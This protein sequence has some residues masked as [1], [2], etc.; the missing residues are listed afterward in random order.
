M[1]RMGPKLLTELVT[2]PALCDLSHLMV[3]NTSTLSSVSSLSTFKH[4][5][6]N[7][8]VRPS[9]LLKGQQGEILLKY[10]LKN[11]RIPLCATLCYYGGSEKSGG[12]GDYK[13]NLHTFCIRITKKN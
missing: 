6:R 13:R 7:T 5:L 11:I 4:K 12:G 3:W 1:A 2:S 8:P 9:P 10:R